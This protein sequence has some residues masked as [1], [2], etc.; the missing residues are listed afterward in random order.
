LLSLGLTPA[1]A[2]EAMSGAQVDGRGTD[3]L[4]REALKK[5]GR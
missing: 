5:V 4:L 2:L 3:E 1:E